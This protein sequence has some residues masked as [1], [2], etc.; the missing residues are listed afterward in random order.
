MQP[1]TEAILMAAAIHVLIGAVWYSP[2]FFGKL[3]QELAGKSERELKRY[4][5]SGYRATFISALIMAY[6]LSH[7]ISYT[8]A[9]TWPQGASAGFWLWMG[10]VFAT[11]LPSAFFL[12]RPKLLLILDT[13][14][15]LVSLVF[16]GALLAFL[17]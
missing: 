6:V 13:G 17:G 15:Y 10:F 1:S 3:W 2:L 7:M 12:N 9:L 4:Q 5:E 14:Y 11:Q 8:K 16:M